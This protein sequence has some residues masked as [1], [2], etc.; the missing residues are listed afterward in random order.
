MLYRILSLLCKPHF[1]P[2]K[3]SNKINLFLFR[4]ILN[5]KEKIVENKKV[6]FTMRNYSEIT[7]MR[8]NSF[9]DKEPETLQWINT[10]QPG[11][12]FLDIGANVGVYSL[13]AAYKKLNVIAIEP[14]ALNFA[15]LNLNIYDNHF[16]DLMIA[17]PYSIHENEKISALNIEYTFDWGGA[18]HSFDRSV[19]WIGKNMRPVF[20][21]GSPGIT[22]DFLMQKLDKIPSHIKIDV[23]GNELLVLRGAKKTLQN[24]QCKS[25][26][27]ELFEK[28]PEYSESVDIL[29]ES[30]FALL[31][32]V[33]G[34]PS[35]ATNYIFIKGGIR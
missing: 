23:D 18:H 14:D 28:H 21:Q 2:K 20:K 29:H 24:T 5:K 11:E 32:K 4:K 33:G 8:I 25:V 9:F 17:Y 15:L 12:I 26:L 34:D 6:I 1:I 31:K 10:F 13:Y 19:D 22:I 35:I 27:I 16:S 30:G 7:Q 3:I